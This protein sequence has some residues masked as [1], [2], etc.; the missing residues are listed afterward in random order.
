MAVTCGSG[1]QHATA[2]AF[3][4][5]AE[6]SDRKVED[7]ADD[8][9]DKILLKVQIKGVSSLNNNEVEDLKKL[10]KESSSRGNKARELLK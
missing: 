10:M 3:S 1:Y 9:Y 4:R 2:R 7:M 5:L 6:A 8:K